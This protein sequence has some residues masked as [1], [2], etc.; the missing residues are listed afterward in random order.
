MKALFWEREGARLMLALV[1]QDDGEVLVSQAV[2]AV[3]YM[4]ALGMNAAAFTESTVEAL[5]S[6]ERMRRETDASAGAS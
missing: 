5:N 3:V 2:G 6:K 1:P 4:D